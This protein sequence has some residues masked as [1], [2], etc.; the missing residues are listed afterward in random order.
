MATP[1][2]LVTE[3]LEFEIQI[4]C[5][6]NAFSES[7]IIMV[8]STAYDITQP[9]FISNF[10]ATINQTGFDIVIQCIWRVNGQMFMDETS[11]NGKNSISTV[12]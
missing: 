1:I 6:S 3:V 10:N 12:S 9:S 11:L 7:L 5:Q 2:S 8:N 4:Q